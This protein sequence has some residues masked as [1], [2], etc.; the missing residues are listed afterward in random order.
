MMP[1]IIRPDANDQQRNLLD[2]RRTDAALF[3]EIRHELAIRDG[4]AVEGAGRS[5]EAE[6]IEVAL[7]D[8]TAGAAVAGETDRSVFDE[9]DD[10]GY[11][12][13]KPPRSTPRKP[14][15]PRGPSLRLIAGLA[16]SGVLGLA[17]GW[18]GGWLARDGM[19]R[20]APL[21]HSAP[22]AAIAAATQS[23][24]SAAA[25]PS[26]AQL[27]AGKTPE[28]VQRPQGLEVKPALVG[29]P[30]PNPADSVAVELPVTE[31]GPSQPVTE[32]T[33]TIKATQ[34]GSNL[35]DVGRCAALPTPADQ[36]ICR[37]P[38]LLRLQTELRR[39]Y[40]HALATQVDRALLRQHQLAW[41]QTRSSITEPHR[42]AQLYEDRIRKLNAGTAQAQ[43]MHPDER[44]F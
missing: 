4:S 41:R 44:G 2:F 32:P 14:P 17:A 34:P 43:G 26:V 28:P 12:N 24:N 9:W 20:A 13:R 39:S 1:Q 42:L 18:V 22:T 33:K 7:T 6:H 36:T 10:L 40:E 31:P 38:N 8:S 5:A 37:D 11:E 30:A 19:S 16:L 15:R 23:G 27:D 21:A 29:R 25:R 3:D 35:A